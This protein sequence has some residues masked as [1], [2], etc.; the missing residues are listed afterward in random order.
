MP[1]TR[2]PRAKATKPYAC[3]EC[4]KPLT[5]KQAEAMSFGPR[6]CTNCGSSDVDIYP[7]AYSGPPY[8]PER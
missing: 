5:L 4:R 3:N 7:P 6:G 2:K 1:E 8:R